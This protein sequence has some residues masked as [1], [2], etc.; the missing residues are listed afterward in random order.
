MKKRIDL[1][2]GSILKGIIALSLPIIGT[3]FLQMAYNMTDMIW[4]GK[5]G[6]KAVAAAGTAGFYVWLSFAFILIPKIGGE[7]KVSQNIGK[8]DFKE[9]KDYA[10]TAIQLNIIIAI[11]YFVVIQIFKVPL[12]DFFKIE[13]SY[14]VKNSIVFLDVVS[15]GFIFAFLIPIL[16][17]LFNSYGDSKTPFYMNTIGIIIN[18]IL[19][20]ILVLGYFGIK[21]LGVLGS[22]LSTVI[23]Q[24]I[25]VLAFIIYIIKTKHIF[26]DIKIFTKINWQKTK[27]LV[28]L[29]TPVAIQSALFT[30]IS[31][32]IARLISSWGPYAIAA[33]KV[34]A[35]IESISWMTAG[36]FQG[37][38]ASFVGQNYGAGKENRIRKGFNLSIILISFV[39]IFAMCLFY[40]FSKNIFSIFIAEKETLKFGIDYL[41]IM[42]YSQVFM[43]IEATTAGAFNGI[44]KTMPPSIVSIGFNF[45]RIPL[46]FILAKKIGING[47]WWAIT[48]SSILK[49]AILYIWFKIQIRKGLIIKSDETQELKV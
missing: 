5:V 27:E 7:I 32:I 24:F 3:S 40:F 42:A 38:L 29:G 4:L 15:Y 9:A 30:G 20:P 1:T 44:S 47:I 18:I 33:Q 41:K 8:N 45:L 12:I 39:G 21:P 10:K 26:K 37:A 17:G 23:A 19:N 14:V 34:G 36:G 35:Q 43:C 48:I 11:L 25:V 13:D 28:N 31:M 6:G 46:A 22:A 16:T 2:E 49:G